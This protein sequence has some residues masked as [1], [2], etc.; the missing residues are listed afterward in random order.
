MTEEESAD[1]FQTVTNTRLLNGLRDPD[2]R[3]IWHD[4]VGRYHPMIVRFAVRQGMREAD[5]Q[6]IA[7]QTLMTFCTA[8]QRGKYEREQGRL[9]Y[10]LFGIARNE[11]RNA[12]KKLRRHELGGGMAAVGDPAM[13]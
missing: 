7:Q 2:N 5:A 11:I 13:P 8:Y 6:D 1:I 12:R 4:F 10:W 9:R 3:G